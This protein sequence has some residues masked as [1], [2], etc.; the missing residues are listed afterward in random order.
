MVKLKNPRFWFVSIGCIILIILIG[1]YDGWENL[2]RYRW[3][4]ESF[5]DPATPDPATPAAPAEPPFV[6]P[7]WVWWAIGITIYFML[8]LLKL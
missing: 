6:M 5:T 3:I 2:N 7:E 8:L 4:K 1:H